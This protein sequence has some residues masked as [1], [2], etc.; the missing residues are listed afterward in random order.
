[1]PATKSLFD[2]L[3]PSRKKKRERGLSEEV[4]DQALDDA[5]K[6]LADATR[7]NIAACEKVRKRQSSGKLKLV[8]VPLGE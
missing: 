8:N 4:V 2:S 3:R 6:S 5:L 1:M 7:A